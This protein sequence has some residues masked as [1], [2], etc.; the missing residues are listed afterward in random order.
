[1]GLVVQVQRENEQ[2]GAAQLAPCACTQEPAKLIAKA[3]IPP[4]SLLLKRTKRSQV[5]LFGKNGF[6]DIRT[7]RANELVFQIAV[8]D[9]EP[10]LLE[11][12]TSQGRPVTSPRQGTAEMLFFGCVTQTT[13]AQSTAVGSETSKESRYRMSASDG[14]DDNSLLHKVSALKICQRLDRNLIADTLNQHNRTAVLSALQRRRNRAKWG[15][16]TTRVSWNSTHLATSGVS[17]SH[18]QHSNCGLLSQSG[19]QFQKNEIGHIRRRRHQARRRS[20]YE[21]F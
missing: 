3:S 10:L 14:Y 6:D 7:H 20:N 9:E 4:L 1:M 2:A 18:G 5:L 17:L 12:S 13:D 21:A 16:R 11:I 19:S 15:I 8:A